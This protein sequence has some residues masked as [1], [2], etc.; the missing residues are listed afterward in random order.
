MA[1][2]WPSA[3]SARSQSMRLRPAFKSSL[4]IG[5]NEDRR[6][7]FAS[8][9][10]RRAGHGAVMRVIVVEDEFLISLEIEEALCEAGH[11]VI[12]SSGVQRGA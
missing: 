4:W 7:A 10:V 11:E 9:P 2:H 6:A 12:A 8:M 3:F 1:F 5:G